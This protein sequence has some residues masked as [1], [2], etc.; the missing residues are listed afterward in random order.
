MVPHFCPQF[1]HIR[2]VLHLRLHLIHFRVLR[3]NLQVA[4]LSFSMLSHLTLVCQLKVHC[5][6]QPPLLPQSGSSTDRINI[7]GPINCIS[8]NVY[9]LPK[10]KSCCLRSNSPSMSCSRFMLYP[11]TAFIV[12]LAICA[13][14]L[15]KVLLLKLGRVVVLCFS[16]SGI[17]KV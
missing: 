14:E 8:E 11:V 9:L 6:C 12:A 10:S 15:S 13:G 16:C 2:L 4:T 5:G 17:P 3:V 1:D 7:K